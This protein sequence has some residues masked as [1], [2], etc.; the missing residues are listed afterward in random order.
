LCIFLPKYLTRTVCN[1]KQRVTE[2][3]RRKALIHSSGGYLSGYSATRLAP[4]VEYFDAPRSRDNNVVATR[5]TWHDTTASQR[6]ASWEKSLPILS[7]RFNPNDTQ[8]SPRTIR[9]MSCRNRV[10]QSV[11]M[12]HQP[13]YLYAD[14]Y[15]EWKK[16]LGRTGCGRWKIHVHASFSLGKIF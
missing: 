1:I 13:G 7:R 9:L 11:F 5:G 6:K 4:L 3:R 14:E 15:A 10:Y 2:I 12:S 16:A 8:V